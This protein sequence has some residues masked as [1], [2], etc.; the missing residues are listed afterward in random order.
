MLCATTR[1]LSIPSPLPPPLCARTAQPGALP[2][3]AG[4]A[5]PTRVLLTPPLVA[6]LCHRLGYA[7]ASVGVVASLLRGGGAPG[8]TSARQIGGHLARLTPGEAAL[9]R[10][11]VLRLG[12][13][14][15]I[16][17][18][19]LTTGSYPTTGSHP[20][21][22]EPADNC[23]A[24]RR[25]RGTATTPATQKSLDRQTFVELPVD[26]SPSASSPHRP[27]RIAFAN[28]SGAGG[29]GTFPI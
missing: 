8:A 12:L 29:Q 21:I 19:R 6:E 5:V 16:Q 22:S 15:E 25:R 1:I 13:L 18:A 3:P 9:L 4:A 7:G 24:P 27:A 28:Y 17:V 26:A 2:T 20:K 23:G 11:T 10:S 14:G